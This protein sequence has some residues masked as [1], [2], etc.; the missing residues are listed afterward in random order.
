MYNWIVDDAL[1][2]LKI[3]HLKIA[4]A[5]NWKMKVNCVI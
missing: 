3:D 5:L 1:A 2:S 4:F